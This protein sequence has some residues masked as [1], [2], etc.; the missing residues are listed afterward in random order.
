MKKI[1]VLMLIVF[2]MSFLPGLVIPTS[3]G[4]DILADFEGLTTPLEFFVFSGSSSVTTTPMTVTDSDPLARPGQSGNNDILDVTYNVFDFGGFGQSFEVAGAQDWSNYTSFDFWFFGTG[5]GFTY[6]AEISDNR[7][8]PAVDTSERFDYAFTD[9]T[10]GWQLISIPFTDFTR[11]TDFQPGGAPND[12]FTLTEIWAWAVVLPLG[13]DT[14]YFDD[15]GLGRTPIDDFESGLPAGIDGNGVAIGFITFSD[16]SPVAI[17]TTGAYPAPV[18]GEMAGNNVLQLDANVISFAGFVHAFE[19]A[20]VDSWV[21]QDWST[22]EGVSFWL[23]GNNSGTDLFVDLLENRNPGSTSDDAERW[24]VAFKDDFSG[25]QYFEFPFASFTRKEIGN[26]APNDGLSL[27]EVHGWAFG[28]L[29][30]GGPRIYYL[31][32]VGLY[33]VAEIPALAVSFTS[34]NYNVPEGTTGLITVKLNRSMTAEDPA[35]VSVDYATEAGTPVPDRE[36]IPTAGTLTFINGG[37]AELSF[38]LQTFDDSKY[39]G[40]ERVLLRLTNPVDVAPG[41]IQ[42]ATGTIVDDDAFD[43]NLLDDFEKGINLWHSSADATLSILEIAGDDSQSLPGQ[44][45]FESVL[46]VVTPIEEPSPKLQKQQARDILDVLLPASNRIT[47]YRIESAI[48]RIEQSLNPSY[49]ESSFVLDQYRGSLVFVREQQAVLNLMFI[50][51]SRAPESIEAQR[52]IDLLVAADETLAQVAINRATINGGTAR[53]IDKAE[54]QLIEAQ[55][56]VAAGQFFRAIGRYRNAWYFATKSVRGMALAPTTFGRDFAIG[57]N[58]SFSDGLKFWYYG[59]NTGDV[60]TAE[61]LD[62]RAPDPGPD[63]WSMVWNDE[64]NS[65]AG[66]PPSAAKWGYEI[67]DGSLNGIPGWGNDELQY[68]SDD[69]ANAATD[70][71]GDLVLTVRDADGSLQCYYGPCQ[72]TSARLVSKHKSEFAYGRIEARIQVPSGGPGLWPAFWSLGTDIDQVSWPQTGEIDFMEYVSRLPTEIF[73]TIHGPGYSGGQSYG[74]VYDFGEPVSNAYHTF[75][76][77]WEPDLIKWYVDGIL[78]HSATPADVS[79]NQWVFNDPVYLLL[80]VAVGGN[81]GG[82]VSPDTT[83]P[84]EMRV[85]YVRVYQ[86]PD[87][88]ERFEANFVDDFTGWQE[89]TL[90]FDSFMRSAIQPESAPNDGLGLTE[91]WGYGFRLPEGGITTGHLLFDQ[92]RLIQPSAITVT[93]TGNDGEGSLRQALANIAM[94]G[95]ITFDPALA[96]GTIA[97]TSGPLVP[98]VSVTIDASDAPGLSINGGGTDRALIVNAGLNVNV[99]NLTI[100][101]GFG[102]ELA[103]GVLNNG[104]LALNQ[105][106]LANNLVTTSGNDFWKGGGGIYNGD[107]STLLLT[108]STVRDN[109][110]SGGPGGGVYGYFNSVVTI[111]RST[112]SGNSASDVGGGIRSLGNIAIAN[113]TISGNASTGWHGGAI[114]HTDGVMNILNSTIA[115]NTAPPSTTGGVFVGTFTAGAPDLTLVNSIVSGNSDVQC[116]VGYFGPGVPELISGGHN[117]ASDGSC[118]LSAFG[119]QPGTDPLLD[120]LA[121]NGGPTLTQALLPGSPALDAADASVCPA[122]DQ[123]GVTRPQGSGCDIGAFE[124]VVP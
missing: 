94:D 85:D 6:Q 41:F 121:N 7:S 63:G 15:F 8:D 108:D 123:R 64:F 79:P 2:V 37:P 73:G 68:Y 83:F 56:S 48:R 60:I 113:S 47:K 114:F 42:Q 44:G 5:S 23:Y 45:A 118:N 55:N 3:A 82:A 54:L 46:K 71:N 104:N 18:P 87:T 92:V 100:T 21:S 86:G 59:Q 19:N 20:A 31:D 70:G 116:F 22:F 117:I 122:T 33:G 4:T 29:N 110:V 109:S 97:L 57:Q 91:V 80:N 99:S 32:D 9:N 39:E 62:N 53:D 51:G 74:N 98:N 120:A 77:E 93:N 13:A 101:N 1:A 12:G 28:T 38:A 34:N 14:V 84:Q 49:W 30:T 119:D 69:P 106:I 50:A 88:A 124:A 24:T 96:G 43:P 26:G 17:T 61:L 95:I 107:G 111:E 103:G 35:Q 16:G 76:I 72:Y 90:P 36:Y 89:V 10:P 58:W 81:F 27:T 65:P 78:Y 66:T 115:N 67:G 25:W 102:F 52:A 11:A 105:V 112:L 40:D 75:A